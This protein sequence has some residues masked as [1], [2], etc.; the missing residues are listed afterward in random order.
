[1]AAD[2]NRPGEAQIGDA[3][4][5]ALEV[6]QARGSNLR[7]QPERVE[8]ER[9][10]AVTHRLRHTGHWRECPAMCS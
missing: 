10:I 8:E 1:M 2:S 6:R 5:K 3:A 7:L 9:G 4:D